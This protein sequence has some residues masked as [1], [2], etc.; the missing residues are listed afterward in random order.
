VVS[1]AV[2]GEGDGGIGQV[3]T[4]PLGQVTRCS[5]GRGCCPVREARRD[6]EAG[7]VVSGEV[8][9]VRGMVDT[10]DTTKKRLVFEQRMAL[11]A[12]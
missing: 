6:G 2:G 8:Y 11:G 3:A 9:R 10:Y 7:G 1:V 4:V 12:G 5:R